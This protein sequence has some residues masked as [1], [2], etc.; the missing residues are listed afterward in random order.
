MPIK[1]VSKKTKTQVN[2]QKNQITKGDVVRRLVE[3]PE[4][5]FQAEQ[6]VLNASLNLDQAKANLEARKTDLLLGKDENIKIDGKNAETRAAQL[7]E[8]TKE[9]QAQVEKAEEEL[10][11]LRLELN[12]L[13]NEF[14]ALQAVAGLL[15][16]VAA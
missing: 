1:S 11:R 3:L 16:V 15:G 10:A 2:I 9:E 4:A 13:N 7:N 6:N 8:A 5:I 14:R 12:K